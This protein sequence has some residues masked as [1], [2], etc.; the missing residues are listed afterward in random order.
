MLEELRPQA[1]KRIRTKLVLEEI[2]KAENIETTEE[3]LTEE[4]QKMAEAYEMEIDK[5]RG[6]MGENEKKQMEE[7]LAV[8]EAIK[9]LVDSA[10]EE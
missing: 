1:E 2:V 4:L 6:F 7:G 10:V 5:L 8:Q 3:R 9:L